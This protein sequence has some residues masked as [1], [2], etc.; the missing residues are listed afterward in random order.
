[1]AVAALNDPI[2]HEPP[3]RDAACRARV[4]V[5][6]DDRQIRRLVQRALEQSSFE[7]ITAAN[8]G[9]A[10]A[11]IA[12]DPPDLA[13]IDLGLPDGPGIDVI[14]TIKAHHGAALPC[15]VLSGS[16]HS[17]E[18]MHA[19]DAGAD[20][21]VAKPVQMAELLKRVSAFERT[22]R[23][24]MEAKRANEAAD[25]L[26]LFAAETAALL[27]HDLNNGLSVASANLSY[28]AETVQA[29]GEVLDAIEGSQRALRRMTALVRNFVDVSRFEDAALKPSRTRVDIWELLSTSAL[30]HDPRGSRDGARLKLECPAGLTASVDPVLLERVIHNLLNNATRYVERDGVVGLMAHPYTGDDGAPWLSISVANTGAG[31]PEALR[32]RLFE[33]YRAGT[34]GRAQCGMGLYFCRLACESLGG[35]IELESSPE[36]S[37]QFVVRI[38]LTADGDSVWFSRSL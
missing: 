30:I 31:V 14:R 33:K 27:A 26:R 24:F 37:T 6:D 32:P 29:D 28:V 25:R 22:R 23:A 9:E 20:D 12:R 36:Y 3:V 5:V 15:L 35:R 10:L 7:V 8:S 13:V 2:T 11:I 19:F 1:M 17:D 4:L 21:F 34:D 38:P 18:R 16:V